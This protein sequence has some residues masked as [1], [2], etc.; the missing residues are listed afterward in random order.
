MDETIAEHLQKIDIIRERTGAG[1]KE[2]QAAL[3][4][5]GGDVVA[6][7]IFLEEERPAWTGMFHDKSEELLACLK[8]FYEKS[9]ATK[10]SFKKDDRTLFEVPASAGMLGLV[11]MLMSGELAVMGAIGTVVALLNKCTLEI[12]RKDA[13]DCRLCEDGFPI[14]GADGTPPGV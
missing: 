5:T 11:G 14:S 2:A 3:D 12:E 1:Y 9:T 10:L 6:A 8:G 7:L 13:P 4:K